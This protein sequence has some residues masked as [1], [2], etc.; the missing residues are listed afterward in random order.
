[1]IWTCDECLISYIALLWYIWLHSCTQGFYIHGMRKRNS[2]FLTMITCLCVIPNVTLAFSPIML[3]FGW[4]R[5]LRID[6][7]CSPG[8]RLYK[9]VPNPRI[10]CHNISSL[11]PN[12]STQGDN[13]RAVKPLRL[14]AQ[15]K[16]TSVYVYVYVYLYVYVYMYGYVC[17]YI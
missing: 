7:C 2:K 4:D 11:W 17:I 16:K 8:A 3:L 1:M 6:C 10:I 9:Y 12:E 14:W 13:L 5:W 15:D